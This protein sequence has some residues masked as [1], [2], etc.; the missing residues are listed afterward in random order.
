ME[1]IHPEKKK[2]TKLKESNL[3]VRKMSSEI[4]GLLL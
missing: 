3:T 4:Q 2:K 1:F